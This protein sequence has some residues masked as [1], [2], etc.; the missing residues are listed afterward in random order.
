M[1]DRLCDICQEY[2]ATH[3]IAVYSPTKSCSHYLCDFDY[4]QMDNPRRFLSLLD[5][6]VSIQDSLLKDFYQD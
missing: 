3:Q 2:T 4:Q 5:F 6:P 1:M